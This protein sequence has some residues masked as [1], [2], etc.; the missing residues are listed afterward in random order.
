MLYKL[1]R[2]FINLITDADHRPGRGWAG[3]PAQERGGDHHIQPP[4][5]AGCAI[6]LARG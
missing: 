5:E 4:R 6:D 1:I 3:K 2:F